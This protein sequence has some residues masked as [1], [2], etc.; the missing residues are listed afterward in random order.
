MDW[1]FGNVEHSGML[2]GYFLVAVDSFVVYRNVAAFLYL[3]GQ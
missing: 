1:W 3:F 2:R